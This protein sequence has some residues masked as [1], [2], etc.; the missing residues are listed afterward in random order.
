[1]VPIL[2]YF[3]DFVN[4]F[5]PKICCCCGNSLLNKENILCS[6]CIYDIP[7]TNFHNKIDNP[8][9]KLFWGLVNIKYATSYFYFLKKSKYVGFIHKLKYNNQREIGEEMGKIFGYEIAD[10]VFSDI[11]LIIPVP[12]HIH[13]FRKRGF[14]QSEMIAKGI[15]DALSKDIDTESVIRN[16]N[17]DTQTKKNL[18]ERRENVRSVFEIK[19]PENI[20][21]KHILLIDDVV[22][23][24]STLA[25]CAEEILKIK[26]T[27]VSIATLGFASE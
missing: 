3:T 22:T 25:S 6:K 8:V 24:G 23:T 4:L 26:N 2:R 18:E 1:M 17:T 5:F 14:N 15:G 10:S 19:K 13:K 11:D 9:N 20:K 7:R 16:Y 12:L 27:Q 21:N